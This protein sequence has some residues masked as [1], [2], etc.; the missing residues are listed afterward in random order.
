M[1]RSEFRE[2]LNAYERPKRRLVDL[3]DLRDELRSGILR[4]V[5]SRD[6]VY[7]EDSQTGECI[8]VCDLNADNER[9]EIW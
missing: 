3:V 5:V 8:M 9:K 4:P 1:D 2:L 7:I 6:I